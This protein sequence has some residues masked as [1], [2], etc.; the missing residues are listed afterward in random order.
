[1][2]ERP[3]EP[4][5]S[6]IRPSCGPAGPRPL[7]YAIG[8]IGFDFG[9]EARRDSFIQAMDPVSAGTAKDGAE[10][11]HPAN[12]YDAAQLHR[13]LSVNPWASDKVT[14]TLKMD[15]TP[16]YALEAET[17][18]GM[19]WGGT[20]L[21]D[22]PDDSLERR[23]EKLRSALDYPPVSTIY[24]TFRDAIKAQMLPQDHAGHVSRVSIP[25]RLTDRTV[26]LFSGQTL[27]VVEVKSRGVYAWDEPKLVHAVLKAV[28]TDL[29]AR[30]LH[31][32]ERNVSL[33][34]RSLLDKIYYQF[35]NLGQTSADRA[36]NFAGTNAFLFGQ[37]FATGLLAAKYVP[38]KDD[39]L[40]A[41]DTIRVAKSPFCRM[42]SDCQDVT[43]TFFD[44]EDERRSKLS[45]LETY[46]VSDDPVSIG[47]PHQF[48]GEM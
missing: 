31:I 48:L 5:R 7:I 18:V 17:P 24:R 23:F 27:Q 13:Y 46:D 43:I 16:I 34:I 42:D 37:S 14:W 41:L 35:R 22:D 25:G 26:R 11:E 12:P 38:G 28:K 40:Y 36:L 1:M 32:D 4:S 6:G 47:P 15:S 33:T 29:R 44:P 3:P 10:L 21:E 45:F 30:S 20:M 19:D 2:Q 9:T 39:R 8:T